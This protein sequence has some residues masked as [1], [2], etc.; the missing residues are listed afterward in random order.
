MAAVSS[1]GAARLAFAVLGPLQVSRHGGQLSLGGRQQRAVLALLLADAGAAVSVDRLADALWGDSPPPGYAATIQTYIFHLRQILEPDRGRGEASKLLITDPVGY[2]LILDGAGV[3]AVQFESLY[4]SGQ[5][6]LDRGAY[7]EALADLDQALGLWRGEV[8]ADLAEYEFASALDVRLQGL[9]LAAIETRIEVQ[10]A[11]GRHQTIVTDL[12]QLTERY[13]LREQLHAQRMLALYRCGRQSEA[14]AAYSQL[15]QTLAEELGI[16][17]S[18]P[19]Q[20]L[21]QSV[22]QQEPA[23]DWQP[24]VRSS[25]DAHTA[26]AHPEP[27]G[28]PESVGARVERPG[29]RRRTRRRILGMAAAVLL[30]AAGSVTALVVRNASRSR[31]PSLPAN[32]VGRLHA[33]G[34]MTDAVLVGVS[35]GGIAYGA[36]SLWTVNRTDGTVSRIDPRKH[37]VIQTTRVG[38]SPTAVTVSREDVWIANFGDG[39]VSRVNAQTNSEVKRIPVGIEPAAIISGPNGVWVAN[40]G[41]DTIQRIDP[42]HGTTDDPIAVGNGPDGLA[43]DGDTMWVTNA[44]DGTVS[45][46]DLRKRAEASAP[47][48]VGAGPRGVAVAAGAVWVANS[49]SQSVSRIDPSSNDVTGIPVGD[50]PNSIAV[51]GNALWVSNEYEGTVAR[52]DPRTNRVKRFSVGSSPRGVVAV[53][54]KLWV[55]SAAFASAAHTGGTL[56]V[57]DAAIPGDFGSIDP[58]QEYIV[59]T[60]G[61]ER[62]VYD[63]LVTIRP[64]GAVAGQVLVPDLAVAIPRPSNSGRSYTFVLRPGIRYSTGAEV[65]ATDF[66]L[67]LFRTLT[68]PHGNPGLY[69]RVLG[70]PACMADAHHCRLA[71]LRRGVEAD[72]LK[73]TITFHLSEP[74]P[75]FL[76]KL[77]EFIYPMPSDAPLTEAKTPIPGTGPYQIVDYSRKITG[78]TP[79]SVDFRLVR[80]THFHQWSFAAQPA[81]YPDEIRFRRVSGADEAAR[82]VTSGQ[83]DVAALLNR[84]QATPMSDQLVDDLTQRYT[85]LVHT[86]L[87]P[88]TEYWTLN[89]A[90]APFKDLRARQALN[91]ALDRRKYLTLFPGGSQREL[92]CQMLPPNFPGYRPYCPYTPNPA[93]GQYNGPDLDKAKALVTASRTAGTTVQVVTNSGR[94]DPRAAF[95]V[96]TLRQLGYRASVKVF[97]DNTDTSAVAA[98]SRSKTQIAEDGWGADYPQPANF[99]LNL[100]SCES[101]IPASA[102]QYNFSE[103]CNPALDALAQQAVALQ[104]TNPT[105]A[106]QTWIKV[107]RKLTDEAPFVATAN[108][109]RTVLVSARAGNYQD[110]P[111]YGPVLSQMWVR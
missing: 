97:P 85:T 99:Y 108:P 30:L 82:L 66:L 69:S 4:R 58:S 86:Q 21:Y 18:Q 94:Q 98:D 90:I 96:S 36:G 84:F 91:Y 39:T 43:L 104:D 56:T 51:T 75:D 111:Y 87:L 24:P 100:F 25:D 41:D 101:F 78:Q 52:I 45:H 107:D 10:L 73:R 5:E 63:G 67:G 34:S 80:N 81:G 76:Y 22:L 47:V 70:A 65:Q 9:R 17:P 35:P 93:P 8:L 29:G 53:D 28:G 33:D 103:Y 50:G 42:V 6:A 72:D 92:T 83:A 19:L 26:V 12:D 7:P 1:D 3:D 13:P 57:A 37:A 32:G 23:L 14:L 64:V 102:N 60:V 71:D 49:L 62:V 95:L 40:S 109:E 59:L 54:G 74:D 31:L 46:I 79:R 89:T 44:R 11:L 2:R 61:P 27:A 68:L 105:A 15:R 20:R 77:S 106:V 38:A 48:S 110:N 88:T 55:A 16:D